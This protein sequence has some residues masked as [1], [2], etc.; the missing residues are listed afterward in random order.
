M[1]SELIFISPFERYR[2]Q[3]WEGALAVL[4]EIEKDRGGDRSVAL[5]RQRCE[6]FKNGSRNAAEL[7]DDW[8]GSVDPA[9]CWAGGWYSV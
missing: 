9:S 1:N 2:K 3:E 5:L 4:N 7:P 6:E 8:N